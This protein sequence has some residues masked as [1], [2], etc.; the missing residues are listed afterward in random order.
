MSDLKKAKKAVKKAGEIL[1]KN[2][3]EDYGVE[4][5]AKHDLV[6]DIDLKAEKKIIKILKK[7]G[8]SIFGEETGEHEG[9]EKTWIVDPLDG[10]TNYVLNNPAFSSAVALVDEDDEI[11]LSAVYIPFTDDLF[12]AKKDEGAYLN[13]DELDVSEVDQLEESLIVFCHGKKP[14]DSRKAVELYGKLKTNCKDLRQ[15]GSASIE[16]CMVAQGT[17]E[18]FVFPGA[19]SYDAAPG[20]LIL[21]EAGGKATTFGGSEWSLSSKTL[22]ASNGRI[23]K[24][25]IEK[26][27][28]I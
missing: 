27:E 16:Y 5:K 12:Y 4:R 1:R 8:H 15:I 11:L 20:M 7:T 13:G 21:K 14:E 22:I 25:L 17:S 3:K 26:L 2:Y 9:D 6:T 10:T 23:H 19:P 18:A 24:Q 28:G